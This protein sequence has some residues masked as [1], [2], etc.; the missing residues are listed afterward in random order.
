MKNV[1]RNDCPANTVTVMLAPPNAVP[2]ADSNSLLVSE[3]VSV[4]TKPP[5]GAAAPSDSPGCTCKS[6]PIT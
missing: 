6:L 4:T 5:A 3:L 2:L 1:F